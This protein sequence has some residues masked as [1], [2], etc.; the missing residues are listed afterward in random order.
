MKAIVTSKGQITIP[1]FIRA[2]ANIKPGTK[3]D[4][5]LEGK[6]TLIIHLVSKD[7]TA[8]KGIIKTKRKRPVT[9]KEMDDAIS[10]HAINRNACL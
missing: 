5:E 3:L 7:I 4:F 6:D 1:Q 8:L 10:S 9:L 2:K